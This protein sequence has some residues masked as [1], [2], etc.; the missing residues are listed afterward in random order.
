[1]APRYRCLLIDHDDTAVASTASVHYPAHLEALRQMR[2]ERTPPTLEQWLR[3]NFDPGIM[4][5]LAG[6]LAMT[7]AELE[8]EYAIWRGF[9]ARTVPPFFAGFPELI[10]DFRAA[11]GRVAV[12]SHSEAEVIESHYAANGVPG[13][14]PDLVFGWVRDASR[15]KPSPWPALEALREFDCAPAE[16]LMLDDLKPGVVMS[17]AAGIPLA[18]A[19][20]GHAIPEIEAWMRAHSMGY[21]RQVADFRHFIL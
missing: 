19:G 4:E 15:R 9:T 6:E 7:E 10:R 20:W 17:R 2:P 1:M 12:I 13:S 5:Y 18:A 3:W 14:Q 11:G 16:A 8:R 21:F